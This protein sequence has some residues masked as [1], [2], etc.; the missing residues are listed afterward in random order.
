MLSKFT[1]CEV[2]IRLSREYWWILNNVGYFIRSSKAT[3]FSFATFNLNLNR[4]LE[5]GCNSKIYEWLEVGFK[6]KFLTV[7]NF[8]SNI[9]QIF[10]EI[11]QPLAKTNN[12]IIIFV[13]NNYILMK[14]NEKEYKRKKTSIALIFV[15][16][17]ILLSSSHHSHVLAI[18]KNVYFFT[19]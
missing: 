2:S 12:F 1:N 8:K 6:Y 15:L 19:I 14:L 7:N 10:R 16:N 4:L 18:K 5:V 11:Q 17:S 13:I 9:R 3:Y